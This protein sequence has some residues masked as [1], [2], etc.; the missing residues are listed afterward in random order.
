MVNGRSFQ[1]GILAILVIMQLAGCGGGGGGGGGG[2][3]PVVRRLGAEYH[4]QPG[5]AQVGAGSAYISGWTGKGARAFRI[6]RIR[7]QSADPLS[8]YA[9]TVMGVGFVKIF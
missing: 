8:D 3:G 1:T 6:G 4:A 5:L 9:E 2:S 7:H